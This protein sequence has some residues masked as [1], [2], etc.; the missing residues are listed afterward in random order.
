MYYK[1]YTEYINLVEVCR[2]SKRLVINFCRSTQ[3]LISIFQLFYYLVY[4]FFLFVVLL[5][6]FYTPLSV[7][8]ALSEYQ[9][10]FEKVG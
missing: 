6:L 5:L 7:Y 10:Y 1:K 3:F 2:N 4:Y 9:Q 8:I